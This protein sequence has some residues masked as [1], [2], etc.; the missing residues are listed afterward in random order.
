[1]VLVM[2]KSD[3][4]IQSPLYGSFVSSLYGRDS[5]RCNPFLTQCVD[6]IDVFGTQGNAYGL[7]VFGFLLYIGGL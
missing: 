1:M 2:P 6:V 7:L 5:G 3:V 4:D